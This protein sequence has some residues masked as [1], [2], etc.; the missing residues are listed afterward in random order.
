MKLSKET[1]SASA[2][3]AP[4]ILGVLAVLALCASSPASSAVEAAP[5]APR[6]TTEGSAPP[7][8]D[9]EERTFDLG[10]DV[11]G[12]QVGVFQDVHVPRGETR[13]GDVVCIFGNASIDGEVTGDVV[14]IGGS[15]RIAGTVRHDVVAVLSSV[16]FAEEA[17]IG[18][19]FVNVLGTIDG[20]ARVHHG[21][22][23]NIPLFFHP[24]DLRTPLA[25]LAG[26]L[27]WS[28][29][30]LTV[31]KFLVLL[32]IAALAPERV[33]LLSEQAPTSYLL[34]F[35]V[36]LGGYIGV[37]VAH[38]LL[39]ITVIGIPL[40][41]LL[42]L[43]FL[44]V[45]WLG[46]AGIYHCVGRS[47]GRLFGK[48][49]SLLPAILVG[50][51]PFALLVLVPTFIGGVGFLFAL[52]ARILFWLFVEIPA[53]GLVILTRVGSRPRGKDVPWPTPPLPI[54]APPPPPAPEP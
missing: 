20:R 29:L 1:P 46:V 24:V 36:G 10:V 34:A 25:R 40:S 43:A 14:V 38:L 2:L 30:L 44:V 54:A 15:L 13:R 41:G 27:V 5:P 7:R 8:G 11:R 18:H 12:A 39:W 45:K 17:E 6:G 37:L 19:D 9:D 42:F 23:V 22:T 3:K 33:R 52:G 47:I 48:D 53:V 32:L 50:F 26:I 21:E 16:S 31:L 35:L 49:L 4:W 51:L 28:F